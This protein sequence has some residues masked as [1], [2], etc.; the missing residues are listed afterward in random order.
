MLDDLKNFAV[1]NL[2][3]IQHFF[4]GNIESSINPE[5]AARFADLPGEK[6]GPRDAAGHLSRAAIIYLEHPGYL[7]SDFKANLYLKGFEHVD[8][9][10]GILG[11]QRSDSAMDFHND[12][13]GRQIGIYVRDHG[14]KSRE[15]VYQIVHEMM[16][17]SVGQP[18]YNLDGWLPQP[19]GTL[20]PANGTVT[21]REGLVVPH[22][23]LMP[24]EQWFDLSGEDHSKISTPA[25]ATEVAESDLGCLP[26]ANTQGCTARATV[27]R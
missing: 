16:D 14:S 13:I 12:D 20:L 8:S 1:Q 2:V 9:F 26:S 5:V 4:S 23:V 7:T 21:L 22:V 18:P 11:A 3:D 10:G 19:D 24:K 25:S 6:N 15:E 27:V 17:K